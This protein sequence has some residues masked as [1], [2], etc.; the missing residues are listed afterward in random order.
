MV[1]E[2]LLPAGHFML[3]LKSTK[4]DSFGMGREI[5]PGTF[6]R[7]DGPEAGVPHH[8]FS[9]TEVRRLFRGWE[10]L[11]LIEQITDYKERGSGFYD[12]NPFGYTRWGVLARRRADIGTL[13][14]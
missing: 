10:L 1:H 5:E 3:T 4:A 12:Y 2:Q 13:L 14:E 7:D 8:F 9:E 11:V 6:V